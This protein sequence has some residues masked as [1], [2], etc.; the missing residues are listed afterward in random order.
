MGKLMTKGRYRVRLAA[1][2]REVRRAQELRHLCFRGAQGVDADAFDDLC[3]HVLIERVRD[4]RLAAC[5]RLMHMASGRE[6]GRGY[7]GA[8]YDLSGWAAQAGRMAELGR[9]CIDPQILDADVLR[10]AWGA[11]ARI[12]ADRGVTVLF[13]CSTF[14]GADVARHAG[15]LVALRERYLGPE[16]LRPDVAATQVVALADVKGPAK[17]AGMPPLLRS[18][19]GMGGWVGDHAV[20]DRDLGSLHVFTALDLAAVPVRRAQMLMALA[21]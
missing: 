18:Y 6:M 3:D 14:E 5:F 16:H 11:L 17:M 9:F 8:H 12:S 1:S 2:P 19:L 15:A 13:G 20:I 4:G 10:V 7:A 21:E